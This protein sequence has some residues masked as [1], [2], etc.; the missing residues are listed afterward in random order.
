MSGRTIETVNVEPE[1]R[2][3][4]RFMDHALAT[5]SV[6]LSKRGAFQLQR[7]SVAAYVTALDAAQVAD[8]TT[9]TTL[10]TGD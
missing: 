2:S 9:P 3:M 5:D 8:R 1:W 7:D 4:L 6:P 10:T